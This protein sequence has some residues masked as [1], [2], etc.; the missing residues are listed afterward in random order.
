MCI[1][2]GDCHLGDI[3]ANSGIYDLC[4]S[5]YGC[6][7]KISKVEVEGIFTIS[8]YDVQCPF[9]CPRWT[10]SL[11]KDG[12]TSMLT[13]LN[14]KHANWKYSMPPEVIGQELTPQLQLC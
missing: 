7:M 13:R 5:D 8:K 2:C 3:R 11:K 1:L 6:G 4:D 10:V 14:Q 9:E 12:Q